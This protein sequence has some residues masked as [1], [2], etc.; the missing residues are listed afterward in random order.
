MITDPREIANAHYYSGLLLVMLFTSSWLRLRFWYALVTKTIIISY[1]L[2]AI[3][4]EGLL[5]T[6]NGRIQFLSNNF[7]LLG[8]YIIGAFANY[9]LERHTRI[10]FLQKRTIE[11]EKNKVTAQRVAIE[12]QAQRLS[13]IIASLRETQTRLVNSEKL[14]SLGELTAGIAHEI[15][16]P[17]NFVTNFSEVSLELMNDFEA[18]VMAGNTEEMIALTKSIKENL[19]KI[20]YHGNRADSIVKSMLQHS[21][22]GTGEKQPTD[23]NA[24]IDEYF[25]LSYQG[26]RAKDKDFNATMKMELDKSIGNINIVPQDI[27]RVILNLFTNAFYSVNQKKKSSHRLKGSENYEPIVTV[28]TKSLG[29]SSGDGGEN[30]IIRVRDNGLGVSQKAMSK[31]FQ[32]FFTT[33]PSGEGI[34]LGLSLSHEI[35]TKGHNGT[36]KVESKEGEFAEF[37]ICLPV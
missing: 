37:I 27:G 17:L 34:G 19:E 18:Q 26:L 35:I 24:L 22:K 2:V 8:T 11:A 16:N 33:E 1:E 10:D 28:T 30:I 36:M 5:N 12:Q 4:S 29:S 32:P 25:R 3:Y 20:A 21:R 15:K 6:E 13:R 14:A 23:I 9:S 31:I 7:L